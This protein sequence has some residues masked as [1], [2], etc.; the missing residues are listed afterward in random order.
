M[1]VSW[2]SCESNTHACAWKADM[3]QQCHVTPAMLPDHAMLQPFMAREASLHLSRTA[4]C[5]SIPTCTCLQR[6]IAYESHGVLVVTYF[7]R[8]HISNCQVVFILALCFVFIFSAF[9]TCSHDI[10]RG[11]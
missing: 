2:D 4:V 3:F 1:L 11:V 10:H 7:T 6:C 5:T 8:F 9:A